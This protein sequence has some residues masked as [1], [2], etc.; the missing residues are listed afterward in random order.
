[1][2]FFSE[3]KQEKMKKGN[4]SLIFLLKISEFLRLAPFSRLLAVFRASV[5]VTARFAQTFS[6]SQYTITVANLFRQR[7]NFLFTKSVTLVVLF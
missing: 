1:M 4:E 5:V 7:S 3:T 2:V 6:I